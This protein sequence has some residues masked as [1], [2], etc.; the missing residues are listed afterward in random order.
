MTNEQLLHAV[1][2]MPDEMIEDAVLPAVP[3][4]RIHWGRWAG[5]AACLAVAVV[6][7]FV[8][9]YFTGGG[10][11]SGCPGVAYDE[12]VGV[13]IPHGPHQ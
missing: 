8:A 12:S 1:G 5:L 13:T 3:V 11:D 2:D 7:V 10:S 4:R 6:C 9:R